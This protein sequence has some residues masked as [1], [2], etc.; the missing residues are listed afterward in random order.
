MTVRSRAGGPR[1][2]SKSAPTTPD[3]IHAL[4]QAI[5]AVLTNMVAAQ[6][7]L[8]PTAKVISRAVVRVHQRS[9]Q[10]EDKLNLMHQVVD[11]LRKARAEN[12]AL[13]VKTQKLHRAI[14]AK[15]RRLTV[16]NARLHKELA[17]MNNDI[18][19]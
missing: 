17:T 2:N 12:H 9:I 13:L 7:S 14:E 5:K 18:E 6:P 16:E 1:S 10:T 3:V 15:V 19:D 8:A 11:R 4:G